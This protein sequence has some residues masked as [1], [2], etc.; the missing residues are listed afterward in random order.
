MAALDELPNKRSGRKNILAYF[1]PNRQTRDLVEL[2]ERF[3]NCIVPHRDGC[4]EWLAHT[5]STGYGMFQVAGI[6]K[7]LAH[8]LAWELVHGP[9]PEGRELDHL[10]RNRACPNPA[11]LELVTPRENILR[12]TAPSAQHAQQTHCQNGHP[13][14]YT[15]PNGKRRCRTCD[16]AMHR[17]RRM[18]AT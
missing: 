14:T 7:V 3:Q 12:G 18:R 15:C 13:F 16:N 2:L 8:R 5:N 17:M 4:W 1:Q 9:I 10:C 11:H 6:G